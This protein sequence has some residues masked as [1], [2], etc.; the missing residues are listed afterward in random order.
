MLASQDVTFSQHRFWIQLV[1]NSTLNRPLPFIVKMSTQKELIIKD[2]SQ[3]TSFPRLKRASTI[4][5]FERMRPHLK[6]KK[7]WVETKPPYS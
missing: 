5:F 6:G 4:T 7:N 2:Y 3:R 1:A